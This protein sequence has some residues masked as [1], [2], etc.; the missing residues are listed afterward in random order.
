[1]LTYKL[2][3]KA[4]IEIDDFLKQ[5][6]SCFRRLYKNLDLVSDNQFNLELSIK[7]PLLD[8]WFIQSC[9][10]EVKTKFEQDK[11]NKE[12]K[13]KRIKDIQKY[14]DNKQYKNKKSLY[15]LK[16]KLSYLKRS[17]KNNIVFGGRKLLQNL[18]KAK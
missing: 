1:M 13:N 14:I 15:N 5:Y 4:N 6:S 9:K 8:S 12:N 11:T 16:N 18:T 7:Y 3:L 2:K 17:I 10:I